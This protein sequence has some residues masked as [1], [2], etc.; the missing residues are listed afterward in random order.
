[1]K[2]NDAWCHD[3]DIDYGRTS[4]DTLLYCSAMHMLDLK[5]RNTNYW[6]TP[7]LLTV[8]MIEITTT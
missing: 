5:S 1:M 7:L 4:Q 3:F 6:N 2:H 8:A